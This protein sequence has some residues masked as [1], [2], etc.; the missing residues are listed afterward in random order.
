MNTYQ[1]MILD[2]LEEVAMRGVKIPMR[3]VSVAYDWANSGRVVVT[4]TATMSTI[5][6][7]DFDFQSERVHVILNNP[8]G[9]R[10]M[11]VSRAPKEDN[12]WWRIGTPEA[13]AIVA[14]LFERWSALIKEGLA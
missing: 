3:T 6:T 13:D 2:R 11:M 9:P 5:V 8:D 14:R 12:F 1:Q 4:R 7:A 10:S